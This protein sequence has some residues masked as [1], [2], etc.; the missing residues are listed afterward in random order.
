MQQAIIYEGIDFAGLDN[1]AKKF[2]S[3]E[4]RKQILGDISSWENRERKREAF[5][6]FEVYHDRSRQYVID[7]L[8][9]QFSKETVETM[10]MVDTVNL[11]KRI[12]EKQ[13]TLYNETPER[14]FTGMSF[15]QVGEIQEFYSKNG[16]DA[17]LNQAN[18]YFKLQE[19]STLWAIPLMEK[20]KVRTLLPHQFDVIPNEQDPEIAE[21]YIVNN[22]DRTWFFRP[23]ERNADGYNQLIADYDDYKLRDMKFLVWT[24]SA[25]FIFNGLGEMVSAVKKNEIE[26]L[27]FV[28]IA[29]GKDM[30]FFVR[31][32]RALTDFTIQFNGVLS[33]LY[34]VVKMQGWA[35][36]YLKA[37]INMIPER[38]VVGPNVI[39]KLPIDPNMPDV[40]TEFGYASPNADIAGSIQYLE[41]L[42]SLYLTS[43][44]LDSKAISM[45]LDT[46][47]FSSGIERLLAMLDVFEASKS[48]MDIFQKAE[49]KLWKIISKWSNAM[50]GNEEFKEAVLPFE[51][52]EE[53]ECMVNFSKP[54]MVM[55]ESE[56]LDVIDKKMNLGLMTKIEAVEQLRNVDP[57]TAQKI[58]DEIEKEQLEKAKKMKA[59]FDQEDEAVDEGEDKSGQE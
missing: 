58:L 55:S 48:D 44:G 43:R 29:K 40:Q 34:N 41:T 56:Q 59:T 3:V 47:S 21:C 52:P 51:V 4:Y 35:V 57:E 13:A 15:E 45:K 16:I 7:Y 39:L 19:Q 38:L 36:G 17:K 18:C 5:K 49:R 26:M 27:P 53:S 42:I 11:S 20:I 37:P 8:K 9:S 28:D 6:Q 33:D 50:R 32:G 31:G 30:E 24:K 25:N 1:L 23:S 54:K 22:F 14:E 12:V 2:M 10:P 46:Q